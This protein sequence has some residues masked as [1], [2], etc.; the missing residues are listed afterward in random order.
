MKRALFFPGTRLSHVASRAGYFEANGYAL[1]PYSPEGLPG[2]NLFILATPV[3]VPE[4]DAY[5]A[6]DEV[7]RRYLR[8]KNPTC[9]LLRT[10]LGSSAADKNFFNWLRPPDA[11]GAFVEQ[12]SSVSSGPM[13]PTGHSD[14][15]ENVW[16]KFWDGH[17]RS[18]F[19]FHA[20]DLRNN[21]LIYSERIPKKG[22]RGFEQVK[23]DLIAI[24]TPDMAAKALRSWERYRPFWKASPF[25][26]N[27]ERVAECLLPLKTDL[28]TVENAADMS[29]HLKTLFDAIEA[30]NKLLQAL[31]PYFKMEKTP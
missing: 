18:G 1:E 19:S 26:Q 20:I 15:L 6:P 27:M 28:K 30:A 10:G 13:P 4:S 3:Y 23:A 12:C 17:D 21:A 11:L 14:T 9:K 7:W 22:E 29:H 25:E 5:V 24:G 2:A 31:L 8:H 16:T